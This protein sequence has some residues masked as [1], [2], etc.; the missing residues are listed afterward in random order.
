MNNEEQLR[1]WTQWK[2]TKDDRYLTQL[3]DSLQPLIKGYVSRFRGSTI[4]YSAILAQ[5]NIAVRDS[6]DKYDPKQAQLSTYVTHQLN[7]VHR[8]VLKYQNTKYAPEYISQSFGKYEV[9]SRT[10]Q[11]ELG[12]A[13]TTEEVAK[14]MR[15][16]PKI[17]E[18]IE[19]AM[20]PE[21]FTTQVPDEVSDADDF[22]GYV[23]KQQDKDIS[24]LRTSIP[25]PEQKIM[26][27]LMKYPNKTTQDIADMHKMD[28]EE[29]YKMRR[30][31]SK[32]L[33]DVKDW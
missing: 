17:I 7:P 26:D 18:R 13:P 4:P 30:N 10:L 11:N 32:Q 20:A 5:A 2:V 24:Y 21:T 31:W 14:E 12:R 6:L 29:I 9:A 23:R 1:L 27:A 25:E 28:I 15:L 22:D 19:L 8:Y 33:K 3:L 16:S